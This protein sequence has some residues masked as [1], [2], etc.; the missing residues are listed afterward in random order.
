[1][2]LD[3]I[4]LRVPNRQEAVQFYMEAFGYKIQQEFE[5]VFDDGT[6]A[7]C[8]AMEPPEK[9]NSLTFEWALPQ[10]LD[11]FPTGNEYH[12]APEIFISEGEPG[13]VVDLWV[14]ARGGIGGFHHCAFQVEDVRAKMVEWQTKGWAEFTTKDILTCPEDELDQVFTKPNKFTG[15]IIEFIKRG[16]H[17]FC[18]ANV[19]QLM[20]STK[21]L[22]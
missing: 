13:S 19:K 21:D 17:G 8:T 16:Q 5:V 6:K 15:V 3:H 10:V 12:M 7:V 22:K 20:E 14:Q 18:S 1:M 4:A 11:G 2:R 9:V